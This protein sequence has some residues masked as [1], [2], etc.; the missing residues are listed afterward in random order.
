MTD[1]EII[2]NLEACKKGNCTDCSLN[3]IKSEACITLLCSY[4]FELINCQQA[5]I[6]G[7]ENIDNQPAADVAPV[8]HGHWIYKKRTKLVSTGIAKVAEDGAAVIMKKH[9]TIKVPYCSVCGDRGENELDATPF[10]P[11][12]GAKMDDDIIQKIVFHK[13]F[14]LS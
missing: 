7:L 6:E 14:A 3:C 2:K 8:K 5:E 10:C 9:I 1:Y 13:R 11:N 12:C 4:A